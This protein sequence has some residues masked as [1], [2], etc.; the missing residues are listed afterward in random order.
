MAN[1]N[2]QIRKHQFQI[3]NMMKGDEVVRGDLSA[4]AIHRDLAKD[5]VAWK[6]AII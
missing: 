2:T 6:K 3:V 4:K 1:K 5:R